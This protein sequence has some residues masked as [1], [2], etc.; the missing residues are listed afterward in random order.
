MNSCDSQARDPMFV[1]RRW[2]RDGSLNFMSM[3]A[4][5]GNLHQNSPQELN[6]N[7]RLIAGAIIE[8][9]L[10]EFSLSGYRQ[11]GGGI[12]HII[13]ALAS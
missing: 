12:V 5:L 6:C 2:K 8:T 3:S 11:L 9:P 10:A 13:H 1:A 7:R 4:A